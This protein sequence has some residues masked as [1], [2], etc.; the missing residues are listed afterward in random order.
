MRVC[1][2]AGTTTSRGKQVRA[3]EE[4]SNQL[5]LRWKEKRKWQGNEL[6]VEVGVI[7]ASP[8]GGGVGRSTHTHTMSS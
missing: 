2:S 7:V 6:I 1:V 4:Q 5:D 3:H 8:P